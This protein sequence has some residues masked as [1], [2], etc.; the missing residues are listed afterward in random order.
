MA[1]VLIALGGNV[2]DVRAT[3]QKAIS[4]IC[5]MTQAA[6]IARS[7]DYATPPWGD[8]AQARF[9]NACI[10]IG[11]SLDPHALL[12]TL[13]KIEKK[14]GRDRSK[15]TRWGPRTLDLDLLAYDDVSL[16]KPDLTLPHPLLFDRAFVLVPLAE[17]APDRL[18]A[19]RRVTAALAQLSTDG[20]QRLPE[21]G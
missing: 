13:H 16:Q 19:G 9:I 14:F 20:I 7:S 12:F 10:E 17:I 8:E 5:G 3:F 6:L 15:E 11:T 18:I 1:D 4:N 2:G 21:L